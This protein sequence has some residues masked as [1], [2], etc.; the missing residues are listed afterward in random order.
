[1]DR[2]LAAILAADVV[3]YSA[4]MDADEAG[5]HERLKAGRKDLFEPEI[6]RHHG[7]IFKVMGDGMLAEFGSVVDAVECA[8]ALQRGLA[9]R[10]T[11]LPP[12]QHIQV[13][14]GI[15]LG[16]VIVEG[17]DR[18]GEGV[19]VATRI[20]QL[21]DPGGICVSGNVAHEVEK[22]LAFNFESMGE[23][24]VKNIAKPIPVFRIKLDGASPH[25]KPTVPR[26]IWVWGAAATAIL[27]IAIGGWYAWHAPQGGAAQSPSI[28]DPVAIDQRASL[29]VLPFDN[30]S[31]DAEQ[32]F[33]AD[34]ITEDLTTALARVPG[35]L[36]MSRNAAFAY[37]GKTIK[38]SEIAKDLS[39]RYI[40]EGSIRRVGEDMRINAQL[41]D[42]TSGG[43]LWAERFDG[44]WAD[45]FELQDKVVT[46][47]ATALQ[48]K[49]APSSAESAG[50]TSNVEAYEAWLRGWDLR[51]D[52]TTENFIAATEQFKKAIELDPNFGAG[53][54]AMAY[55]Y[56]DATQ[57]KKKAMGVDDAFADKEIVRHLAE[58]AK[59]PST[60]YYAISGQFLVRQNRSDQAI[61]GLQKAIALNPSESWLYYD[62][63]QA[64]IFNGR[65]AD[66]LLFLDSALRINPERGP[67]TYYLQGLAYFSMERLEE[68][69]AALEKV[70]FET[71][72]L[73][74]KYYTAHVL[75][76]AYG[77]LGREADVAKLKEKLLALLNQQNPEGGDLTILRTQNFFAY[78][79]AADFARL[80]EG[81]KKAGVPE[82]PFGVDAKMQDR[83]SGT[84][85]SQLLVGHEL[86]GQIPDKPEALHMVMGDGTAEV[87]LGDFSGEGT[88]TIEEDSYCI[89]FTTL[90]RN[91]HYV[92]RNPGGTLANKNEFL[93]IT[94]HARTEFSIV[95]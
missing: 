31:N 84:E 63:A 50:G 42:S 90:W 73:W 20:E 82:D 76:S 36:V 29:V 21:A 12:N 44:K 62:M 5:T 22:R 72:D 15:N 68:A 60:D 46:R 10:N 17:E 41:I 27:L 4:L 28:A 39:V 83:L 74:A 51:Q 49:L 3:G 19:N 6:A 70:G 89:Y 26:A 48:L 55:I 9:E 86:A 38:P 30:L 67:W 2:K 66:A 57:E 33:L 56:W 64:T 54:A 79:N 53:H 45:V 1:M 77:H 59:H 92:Y 37:K 75:L 87:S 61:E 65:P 95:K 25:A 85:I 35:L 14:I 80:R 11:A 34:G 16:E 13:R 7:R 78:K 81:L 69:A 58:A 24:K 91:C 47:V 52:D 71:N 93:Q 32:G 18:Y 23:Q 88:V 43:H 94:Q 40:L 8:V